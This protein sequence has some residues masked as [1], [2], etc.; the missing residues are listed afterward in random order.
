MER[1]P[2]AKHTHTHTH[3]HT[4]RVQVINGRCLVHHGLSPASAKNISRLEATPTFNFAPCVLP[5]LDAGH[6]HELAE[7]SNALDK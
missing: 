3:T 1:I 6:H 5:I 4:H 2:D 7:G